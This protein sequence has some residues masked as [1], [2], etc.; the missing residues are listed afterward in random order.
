MAPKEDAVNGDIVWADAT[1]LAER[2]RSRELSPVEVV[3]AF[4][5]RIE[6]V[7]PKVNAVVVGIDDAL[8]RALKAE[9]AV[10]GGERLGPLHGVPFTIKDCID[11]AGARTTRGSLLFADRVADSDATVVTRLREAGGVMIGKTNL[12]EFALDAETSNRV[13]GT[14][15][16]PWDQS[17]T[18]GGSSG[19]EGAAIGSG[20][21]PLGM[22]SDVG[23]SIRIPA[24]FNGIVGLKAT[25]G[26]IPLTGHWPEV[27]MTSMHVGPMAC[28][29]RD[30]A[31][32]LPIL[33]GPDG[34]DSYAA[35]ESPPGPVALD[36]PLTGLR[37]AWSPEAGFAPVDRQVQA[38]V[39]A[40]AAH[41]ADQGAQVEQV[42]PDWLTG[43]NY[44]TEHGLIFNYEAIPAINEL[45]ESRLGDLAPSTIWVLEAGSPSRDRYL[46]ARSR[47]DELKRD[48][49]EFLGTY[50]ALLCPTVPMPAFP[51]GRSDQPVEGVRVPKYHDTKAT[52]PW[53]YT[54]SPALSVPFGWTSDGL[55][56]GVQIV[57]RHFDE[58]TVLRLGA[59][60]ETGADDPDRRPKL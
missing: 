42:D 15:N 7:N 26:H 54:G 38:V 28:S 2:I 53:D 12:P 46:E 21:S 25:H 48:T 6:A 27:L 16:N 51:H 36:G 14:T 11:T 55:P 29:V 32:S 34:L 17:R 49:A 4:L 35:A 1:E 30:I 22:G 31:L 43:P 59:A 33:A 13:F 47:I 56:I 40:A 19:G 10:T 50:H 24:T 60:V 3:R 39:T 5:D 52:S 45:G 8:D 58:A 41:L 23:G 44:L 37:V 57:G 18:A 9:R 20:M